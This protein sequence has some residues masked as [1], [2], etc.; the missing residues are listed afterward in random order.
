MKL[1]GFATVF[2]AMRGRVGARG[3]PVDAAGALRRAWAGVGP[4]Y[5]VWFGMVGVRPGVALWFRYT[6]LDGHHRE[7]AVW[8]VL[9]HE[10]GVAAA[11]A[12]SSLA[13]FRPEP[14]QLFRTGDGRLG[15]DEA[16]GWPGDL[17]WR[18][19]LRDRGHAH[20]IIP[21]V[22][23]RLGVARTAYA[24]PYADLRV[25]GVVRHGERTFEL[26]GAP[27]MLGHIHGPAN[28]AHRW[29]WAHCN[30]FDGGADAVFE[31]LCAEPRLGE[32]GL[33]AVSSF[34][35]HLDGRTWHFERPSALLRGRGRFGGALWTFSTRAGPARLAGEALLPREAQVALARYTDTDG[36]TL[37]CRN[38]RLSALRVHLVDPS[39]GV[40]RV[41]TTSAGA[42]FEMGDRVPPARPP[43][44]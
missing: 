23:N 18:L 12:V 3:A 38:S 29:A 22:L 31:G 6:L 34:I 16:E 20:R 43:D 17:E 4:W 35:L 36:S 30:D 11:K 7:A 42:A 19:T 41:L 25:D 13:A 33:P 15:L 9:F 39:R 1:P 14:D 24:T 28:A 26:S 32:R 5:E 37:W 8:G 21:P 10:R 40:D 44:L 2:E 27:G